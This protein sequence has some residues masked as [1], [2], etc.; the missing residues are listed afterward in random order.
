VKSRI[1][2]LT[3]LAAAL[4]APAGVAQAAPAGSFD[5]SFGPR[6][7]IFYPVGGG[8]TPASEIDAVAVQPDGKIVFAGW[9]TDADGKHAFLVGRLRSD[10]GLD[11][12]FGDEGGVIIHQLGTGT[13]ASTEARS[14]LLLPD[15]RMLVGGS[16]QGDSSAGFVARLSPAGALDHTFGSNGTTLL[17]SGSPPLVPVVRGLALEPDG[18]I[19]AVGS[20]VHT[21]APHANEDAYAARL[22][23][24]GSPDGGFGTNGAEVVPLVTFGEQSFAVLSAVAIQPGGNILAGGTMSNG[25]PSLAVVVRLNAAGGGLDTSFGDHNGEAIFGTPDDDVNG[26][27][28]EGLSLQPDGKILAA[29]W[30]FD[31]GASGALTERLLPDDG[32]FDPSF[33]PAGAAVTSVSGNPEVDAVNMAPDG[34]LLFGGTSAGFTG[35]PSF[36]LARLGGLPSGLDSTFGSGGLVATQIGGTSS[37]AVRALAVQSDGKIVAGGVAGGQTMV[38]RLL[39]AASDGGGGGGDGG[40]G[41]NPNNQPQAT[42][43]TVSNLSL[44]PSF[45]AAAGKG[46]TIA[47]VTGTT[48]DYTDDQ[49]AKATFT[50]LRPA[51]GIQRGGKCVKPTRRHHKGKRCKRLATVGHFSH[52]DKA[53]EN[54]FRF[55]GRLHRRKLPPAAYRLSVRALWNG[56]LGPTVEKGF[57]IVRP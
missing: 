56:R 51:R 25:G 35:S 14:L 54:S 41:N 57:R 48:V 42:V 52:A 18:K 9:A 19:A 1:V 47:T 39:G 13:A 36:F 6:G 12:S 23:A 2:I 40:G 49:A 5:T 34:R 10:G 31:H 20:E 46:G 50:I 29:G 3:A 45:F 4:L 32:A 37:S 15:G 27:S 44:S 8:P 22:S 11:S 21:D 28:I 43:A 16:V 55:T 38:A 26:G 30:G 33:A 17:P 24:S 7:V 53:G